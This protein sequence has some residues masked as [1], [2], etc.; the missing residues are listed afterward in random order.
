MEPKTVILIDNGHGEATPGKRSP[1]GR[2]REGVWARRVARMIVA[3]LR[4]RG[5]DGRLL[6][7]EADDVPLRERVRRANA[8]GGNLLVSIHVNAAGDGSGWHEA[9]GY[10][11]YVDPSAG[12]TA[13]RVAASLTA[14][15]G[16]WL[17]RGN[18]WQPVAGYHEQGLYLC[19][20]TRCAAVLSECLFMDNRADCEFLLT[21]AGMKAV[22]GMHVSAILAFL[23]R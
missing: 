15:S 22:A 17:P 10:G 19:R 21:D 5:V 1:D 18:R 9:R 14:L 11:A 2:L 12:S 23:G 4:E 16:S 13:R 7:P 3:G 8:A 20:H 6:T